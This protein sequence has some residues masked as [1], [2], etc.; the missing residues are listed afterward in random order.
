MVSSVSPADEGP[1]KKEVHLFGFVAGLLEEF[2][3]RGGVERF[4]FGEIASEACGNLD[5]YAIQRR[6]ELLDGEDLVFLGDREHC[7]DAG[8]LCALNEL[9]TSGF[10]DAENF[11]S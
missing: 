4:A 10:F 8:G 11:P 9:P 7:N 1:S 5:H 3:A 6:A 2:A